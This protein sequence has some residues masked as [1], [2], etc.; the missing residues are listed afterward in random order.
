MTDGSAKPRRRRKEARPGEI[1]EAGLAEFT[2]R[3]FGPARME[4]IARRAGVAKG[5]VFR[6]FPTKEALFEAAVQSRLAPVLAGAQ[7]AL[8]DPPGTATEMLRALIVDAH[9]GVMDSDMP[10]IMRMVLTEGPRFPQLLEAYHRLSMARGQEVIQRVLARGVAAGEFRDSALLRAP[11][12]IMAPALM[13]A[14]WRLNFER[15]DPVPREAL[16]EGHLEMV[17]GALASDGRRG[18]PAVSPPGSPAP[19]SPRPRSSPRRRS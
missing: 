17:F 2:E 19:R 11:M 8:A 7:A 18:E 1:L 16:L 3:G 5:T 14:M 10:L 9:R 13:A 12:L 4:D 6:Y 15:L